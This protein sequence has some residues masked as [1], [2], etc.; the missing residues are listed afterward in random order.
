[1]I[2]YTASRHLWNQ[3]S[4]YTPLTSHKKRAATSQRGS[5]HRTSSATCT[6]GPVSTPDSFSSAHAP[7][8]HL[9]AGNE[10]R[11]WGPS[12][13]WHRGPLLHAD[14]TR[15]TDSPD[16]GRKSCFSVFKIRADGVGTSP[17]SSTFKATTKNVPEEHGQKPVIQ[18]RYPKH[19]PPPM[20]GEGAA[21]RRRLL[22]SVFIPH[23]P[24]GGAATDK[25]IVKPDDLSRTS[26]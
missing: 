10:T 25:Q 15:C 14:R 5:E 19:L 2:F 7:P 4:A 1:M 8:F 24:S 21:C 23:N 20:A 18:C 17:I 3:D 26:V 6:L 12:L 16:G 13:C 22:P 11:S 9:P